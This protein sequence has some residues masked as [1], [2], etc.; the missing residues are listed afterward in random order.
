MQSSGGAESARASRIQAS[1][2]KRRELPVLAFILFTLS[3]SLSTAQT[4][5]QQ[6][7]SRRLEA[8]AEAANGR[9]DEAIASYEKAI[10]LSPREPS[11]RIELGAVLLRTAR[12]PDAI[13]AF[14]QAVRVSPRN[15][16][17]EIGLAQ[18]YR[19]VHNYA[20]AQSTLERAC[21]EHPK[22]AAPLT[23][24]GDL[25]IE[26]EIFDPA[27][28]HLNAALTLAPA[29]VEAR[30]RL[31]LAYKA[32]GDQESALKQF[33]KALLR[34]PK[35]ALAYYERAEI[36]YDTGRDELALHDAEEVLELQAHNPRGRVLLGKILLRAPKGASEVETAKRCGRAVEA[37]EPLLA[38]QS[39]D[40]GMLFLLSRAYKCAGKRDE[41]AKTV[42]LLK[43]ALQNDQ[44]TRENRMQAKHLSGRANDLALKNDLAGAL[45]LLQQAVAKDPSYAF[46]YSQLAKIYY[47]EGD[48]NKA[49]ETIAQALARD[50]YQPDFRYVQGKILEKQGRFDE[51][52]AAFEQT[53]LINPKESDAFFEIGAICQQ[54]NDRACA[55]AAYKKAAELSPDD[56]DYRRALDTL[57]TGAAR[58]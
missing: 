40:S 45:D 49:S 14:A 19:N 16:D 34:D 20:E 13:A 35:N 37:L 1:L 43:A 28:A 12:F 47:S 58:K 26:L 32:K 10:E 31:A 46:S 15:V 4:S 29:N 36:Y 11:L 51:A 55:L 41:A 56:P 53:T 5:L 54:R 57:S 3:A 39:N 9:F 22:N 44:T 24:L 50:P 33:A 48:I 6:A 8:R 21:R 2:A 18:A 30:T 23:V 27:I 52:L 38:T 25:D 7:E 17:A 42:V